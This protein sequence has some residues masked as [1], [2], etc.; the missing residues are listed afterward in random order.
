[1]IACGERASQLIASHDCRKVQ[2]TL[3]EPQRSFKPSH[4]TISLDVSSLTSISSSDDQHTRHKRER[5]P[6]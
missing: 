2:A 1:M 5:R 6:M 4:N 3:E